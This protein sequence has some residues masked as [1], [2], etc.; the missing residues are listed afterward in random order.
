MTYTTARAATTAEHRPDPEAAGDEEDEAARRACWLMPETLALKIRAPASTAMQTPRYQCRRRPE[1][2]D[3]ADGEDQAEREGHGGDVGLV[4]QSD[5]AR[6]LQA[7]P[8]WL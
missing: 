4:A 5:G 3:E 6:A 2:H 8:A 7:A 1:L